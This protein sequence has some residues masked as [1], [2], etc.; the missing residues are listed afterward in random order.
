[1]KEKYIQ[2]GSGFERWQPK[3]PMWDVRNDPEYKKYFPNQNLSLEE[4][5]S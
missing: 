5:L 4:L 3:E 2:Y 1:M